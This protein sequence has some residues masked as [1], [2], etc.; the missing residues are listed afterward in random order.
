MK[1][2]LINSVCGIRSTGR[3]CTALAAQLEGEGYEVKIA[4]GRESVPAE[5]LHYAVRIGSE[6]GTKWHGLY[7]RLSDASGFGSRRATAR[8]LRW[9]E[10][11]DPDLLWLHNLHGYYINVEM[12]FAWIKTRPQMQVRWTLHDCWAFTGHCAYFSAAGCSLWQTQCKACPQRKSYPKSLFL[13]RS[14]RNFTRKRAAFTG[15]ANL[16]LLTPSRWLADL[17]A[18]S[19]LAGYPIEVSP[20]TVDPAVFQPTPG[21]FRERYGLT[22]KRILLGVASE[23]S[24]RKGLADFLQLADRIDGDTVIVLVGL[25]ERQRQS[26]K[27]RMLGLGRTES[28]R[29]L[30]AIYTAADVFINPSREETFG[31]TTLEAILCGTPAIVYCGTACEEVVEG[32]NGIAVVPTVEGICEALEQIKKEVRA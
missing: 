12:L 23:W 8:F 22:D 15:V 21:D 24:E 17:V 16:T 18:K 31:M 3:I 28:A 7:A 30:A 6:R 10:E 14:K 1:A 19:F 29:E 27:P 5:A 2:L 25:N 9:A 11:Y 13:D 26:L 20:N 32:K 4:Y